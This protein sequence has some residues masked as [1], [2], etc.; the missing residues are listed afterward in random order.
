MI[1]VQPGRCAPPHDDGGPHGRAGAQGAGEVE[2]PDHLQ[3]RQ[4]R[5]RELR[6][7]AALMRDRLDPFWLGI[8][9][10]CQ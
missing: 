5:L 8:S 3:E 4:M 1:L 10:H 9:L 6:I 7:R 2:R